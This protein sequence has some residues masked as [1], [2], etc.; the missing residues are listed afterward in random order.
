MIKDDNIVRRTI[1]ILVI[2]TNKNKIMIIEWQ[3]EIEDNKI[4]IVEVKTKHQ[5]IFSFS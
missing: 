5:I 3:V 2:R 1:I 4:D